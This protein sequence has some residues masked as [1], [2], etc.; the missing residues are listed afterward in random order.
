MAT[1]L[2]TRW[3]QS[4]V[5]TPG[6]RMHQIADDENA[7]WNGPAPSQKVL[8]DFIRLRRR[9]S[10]YAE[11]TDA[12]R[13]PKKKD[14]GARSAPITL[15]DYSRSGEHLHALTFG[16]SFW[17]QP[18]PASE[19]QLFR[20]SL[21]SGPAWIDFWTGASYAGEQVLRTPVPL[22][23]IPIFVRAGSIVPFAPLDA[24]PEETVTAL[25]LRIYPGADG[26]FT[27]KDPAGPVAF[28]WDDRANTLHIFSPSPETGAASPPRRFD[29]VVVRPGRG[30]GLHRPTRPDLEATYQGKELHLSLPPAPP[31]AL[32]P[33]GL[34]TAIEGGNIVLTWQAP[35]S[36]AI[37]RV[38][39]V[40]GPDGSCEDLASALQVTRFAIPL[41]AC[42]HPL[43][44]VVTAMNAG[45]ESAPS[46][47]VKVA[48]PAADNRRHAAGVLGVPPPRIGQP[49]PAPRQ[50]APSP[51]SLAPP[52]RGIWAVSPRPS[53]TPLAPPRPSAASV[54]TAATPPAR[55][56]VPNRKITRNPAT[57]DTYP[58]AKAS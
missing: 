39:R 33:K 54:A 3:F 30:I 29:I 12:G 46:S 40:L 15:N 1:P 50:N 36:S 4:Q 13:T 31:A 25:E 47:S 42:E 17:V 41:S 16:P 26:T 52:P 5:F 23:L 7:P 35:C 45:G 49:A 48:L 55:A 43:E 14:P 32:A 51:A 19:T 11:S 58:L 10:L 28:A 24:K 34:S 8:V 20:L 44:C 56:P 2:F 21:P 27:L 9:L 37:Y 38:K 18:P 22:E 6:F 57:P 53:A